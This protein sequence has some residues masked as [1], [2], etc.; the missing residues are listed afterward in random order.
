MGAVEVKMR[1]SIASKLKQGMFLHIDKRRAAANKLKGKFAAVIQAFFRGCL[2]RK[3]AQFV[4]KKL[5]FRLLLMVVHLRRWIT[6]RRQI[7]RQIQGGVIGRVLRGCIHRIRT[8]KRVKAMF[9]IYHF[10]M[11]FFKARILRRKLR[12]ME[13]PL[14]VSLTGI[15]EV[16]L[17]QIHADT[18]QVKVSVWSSHLLHIISE[19]D[20]ELLMKSRAPNIT[21]MS[22]PYPVM[23]VP[24][25]N[26]QRR[27][28]G[29]SAKPG[30]V[31]NKDPHSPVSQIW[32]N[33]R[34]TLGTIAGLFGGAGDSA[35]A[36]TAAGGNVG[37]P[38]ARV[39]SP[40]L[41]Q[42]AV[43][44]ESNVAE[45]EEEDSVSVPSVENPQ[46]ES[47]PP[48]R[49]G[50]SSYRDNASLNKEHDCLYTHEDST[51]VHDVP[52]DQRPRLESEA[53]DCSDINHEQVPSD[54]SVVPLLP[55]QISAG[56]N[57][58]PS[59]IGLKPSEI[60]IKPSE[61]GLK[62][63]EMSLKERRRQSFKN[64]RAAGRSIIADR[65]RTISLEN[66]DPSR[67]PNDSFVDDSPPLSSKMPIPQN[68][69][70]SFLD[71]VV[72]AVDDDDERQLIEHE[73]KVGQGQ[74]QQ[75]GL[76][77]GGVVANSSGKMTIADHIS[78]IGSTFLHS[79]LTGAVARG[80]RTTMQLNFG[81]GHK[82]EKVYSSNT[83]LVCQVD[84]GDEAFM[85]P[86]A[87]GNSVLRFDF[88]EGGSNRKFATSTVHLGKHD[89][90]FFWGGFMS[91]DL[92][93]VASRRAINFS[94]GVSSGS[95]KQKGPEKD[96]PSFQ[97]K[98]VGGA[99]NRCAASYAKVRV[100]G[101]SR[102]KRKS[103]LNYVFDTW[104]RYFM[105]LEG[106]AIYAFQRKGSTT[107]LR[108]IPIKQVQRVS[109]G[110]GYLT[111][112]ASGYASAPVPTA[113]GKKK[114][115]EEFKLVGEDYKNI[116][117]H[118]LN[119]D[120]MYM[121]FLDKA[122]RE[123]WLYN[124]KNVMVHEHGTEDPFD[125]NVEELG[126]AEP[127]RL[128]VLK[129]RWGEAV[130]N[131]ADS[132]V[133]T[134]LI[135]AYDDVKGQFDEAADALG[136]RS[137]PDNLPLSA[138]VLAQ[139]EMNTRQP[140]SPAVKT[141]SLKASVVKV[142]HA[143]RAIGVMDRS[144]SKS[145]PPSNAASPREVRS[146]EEHEPSSDSVAGNSVSETFPPRRRGQ[147]TLIGFQPPSSLM[148]INVPGA[149]R[150]R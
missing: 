54:E 23:R 94:A 62:P 37:G 90:F 121:R 98:L 33:T 140:N 29:T 58:T 114:E 10:V 99:P 49:S 79:R 87:H 30:A 85:I 41:K 35:T 26:Q 1:S 112:S 31:I 5:C 27:G 125:M 78:G 86:A 106:D 13:R 61:V 127:S 93:Q 126:D 59:E 115:D 7:R 65:K 81:H 43:V 36:E 8:A 120:R 28:S 131:F 20:F 74:G 6:K 91:Q 63:S 107:Q 147:S 134:A 69:K 89:G 73:K 124:L 92:V 100:Q 25:A 34:S 67:S 146:V 110:Y 143:Q 118:L 51:P 96:P 128:S 144:S 4:I 75:G 82:V 24:S 56:S 105:V 148:G 122:T 137:E 18:V 11:Q 22:A 2:T 39:S 117:L 123:D 102:I 95:S 71:V 57:K 17:P 145:A 32:R 45:L 104:T 109:V 129:E 55:S 113:K 132:S 139:L 15:K 116:I 72:A 77:N 3:R 103:L 16:P 66:F 40:E 50:G 97:F 130:E 76:E 111:S 12:R 142:R 149:A 135:E 60:G 80:L 119:G 136:L 133:G 46:Q 64:I 9:T 68:K 88:I 42:M 138:D 70:P 150:E 141:I 47:L 44:T 84:L 38:S 52:S 19:S 53:T 83:V 21:Y 48:L 108:K 14:L 101:N